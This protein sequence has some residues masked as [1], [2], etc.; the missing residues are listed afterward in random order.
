MKLAS[1]LVVCVIASVMA[2]VG[3]DTDYY[4]DAVDVSDAINELGFNPV[5]Q[6]SVIDG[7]GHFFIQFYNDMYD[8]AASDTDMSKPY[9]AVISVGH[10]SSQTSWISGNCYVLFENKGFQ[11][12]TA[13][14]REIYSLVMDGDG[15][16]AVNHYF[17]SATITDIGLSEVNPGNDT[18]SHQEHMRATPEEPAASTPIITRQ[19]ETVD[20]IEGFY[21]NRLH[22]TGTTGL[23]WTNRSDDENKVISYSMMGVGVGYSLSSRIRPEVEFHVGD[24]YLA[25]PDI[26]SITS[27]STGVIL[28][29]KPFEIGFG[30]R[31]MIANYDDEYQH[32]EDEGLFESGFGVYFKPQVRFKYII[33]RGILNYGPTDHFGYGFGIGFDTSGIGT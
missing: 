8:P 32:I 6:I 13:D 25:S 1:T 31:Y 27:F 16:R 28:Q 19:E 17:C 26:G 9:A 2:S 24:L 7:I 21:R 14:C 11:I 18:Q 29:V 10:V 33:V 23:V 4:E 3:P 30:G 12:S 5:V 22:I 20:I 15:D